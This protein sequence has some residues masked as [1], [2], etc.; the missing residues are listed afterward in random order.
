M[1]DKEWA[2]VEAQY[3]AKKIDYAT[4]SKQLNALKSNMDEYMKSTEMMKGQ[5]KQ[6]QLLADMNMIDPQQATYGMWQMV[7][8]KEIAS[9]VLPAA[10]ARP[11]TGSDAP[12]S[13]GAL[14]GS[15][16]KAGEGGYVPGIKEYAS[17]APNIQTGLGRMLPGAPRSH[18]S[19]VPKY[20]AWREFIGYEGLNPTKQNQVDKLWD[21]YM[22]GTDNY[23]SW[24]PQDPEVQ[25]MRSRGPA[26]STLR[27]VPQASAT[28]V[29]QSRYPLAEGI[30]K[31]M[32]KTSQPPQGDPLNLGL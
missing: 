10:P 30:R 4:A 19:L 3:K 6:T 32:P 1:F 12:F 17:S 23:K 14:W 9:R 15:G 31:E 26:A 7:L 28:V 13:P 27:T 24:N 8:P 21:E 2:D 5:M 20:K 25:K 18:E 11:S 16:E 29:P 22:K